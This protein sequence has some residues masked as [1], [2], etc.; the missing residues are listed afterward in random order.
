M[1]GIENLESECMQPTLQEIKSLAIAAGEILCTNFQQSHAIRHKGRFDIV[2]EADTASEALI[3]A[4]IRSRYPDH[5]IVTEESGHLQGNDGTWYID[6]LDGT[7][8]YAHGLPLFSISM[9]FAE[10]G[11]VQLGVVYDPWRKE[12]FSAERGKGAFLNDERLQASEIADLSDSLLVTGFPYNAYSSPNNNLDN[13]GKFARMTQGVRR[14]GSA[15]LD[16][17]YVAAG[18]MD[19]YWEISI[20]PWDVAAGTL[21]VEEAGGVVTNLAGERDYFKPPYSIV[22]ANAGLHPVMMQVLRRE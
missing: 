10:H 2:T 16:L 1:T 3:I 12:M 14:L 5:T 18:R 21:I 20:N 22:A 17:A 19:G 7:I 4:G 13:Y 15:A 11:Q 9:A 8:N 6:P